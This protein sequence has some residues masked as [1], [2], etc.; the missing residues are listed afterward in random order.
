[1]ATPACSPSV[2]RRRRLVMFA[3]IIPVLL[4]VAMVGVVGVAGASSDATPLDGEWRGTRMLF[5]ISGSLTGGFTVST[6][7][8][9][10]NYDC[11]TPPRKVAELTPIGGGQ[12]SELFGVAWS[13]CTV[14]P[15]GERAPETVTV[16][17]SGNS[18]SISGCSYGYCDSLTRVNPIPET[19]TT[20]PK[21]TTATTQP[22]Q[23]T[24]T[25]TQPKRP[26]KKDTKR[27][28]VRAINKGVTYPGTSGD[29]Q[30]NFHDDSGKATAT[31]D[32]FQGGAL[33]SK[34]TLAVV[35]GIAEWKDVPFSGDLTGPLYFYVGATDAAGNQAKP[36]VGW[37]QLVVPIEKVSNGCGGGEWDTIVWAQ[38]YFGN[39]HSYGESLL[40]DYDVNFVDACNLHDAG[41]G[42]YTV[43][44]VINGGPPIDFRS[45]P[46]SRVDEK[47]LKDMRTLCARSIPMNKRN[48]L[49][50]CTS[51]GGPL[52]I[53]AKL[54]YN[55]VEKHGYR[56][57][58]A[59][60]MLLDTQKRGARANYKFQE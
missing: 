19:T 36:S 27:P 54:L 45:W 33:I 4:V 60:L 12:F 18:L 41:Y 35:N 8:P 17:L 56:F 39:E 59:D 37:I 44:D 51:T 16:I 6:A 10:V 58:D 32:L 7:E 49:R 9:Q 55:F 30:F 23:T 53:G 48:A 13:D 25:T 28:E 11:T 34:A 15:F 26:P 24:T 2:R 29:L 5:S 43:E 42:G 1:M 47:F 3:S 21:K 22:K 46:R 50:K 38:N 20:Q 14:D 52:S 57:F 31:V 40:D